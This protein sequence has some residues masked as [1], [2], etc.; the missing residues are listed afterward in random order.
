[1]DFVNKSADTKFKEIQNKVM[2]ALNF[3]NA[4]GITIEQ[5]RRCGT[6]YSR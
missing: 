3:M 6:E 2:E 1:M 5:N 4:C